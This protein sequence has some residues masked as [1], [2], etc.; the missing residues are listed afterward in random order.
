MRVKDS[1]YSNFQIQEWH[2]W[3][4]HCSIAVLMCW[5]FHTFPYLKNNMAVLRLGKV[6]KVHQL[7]GRGRAEIKQCAFVVVGNVS[8]IWKRRVCS[9]SVLS[10]PQTGI[11]PGLQHWTLG[12]LKCH[13]VETICSA[14]LKVK[15]LRVL[16]KGLAN[17][18]T[19]GQ[20]LKS[21]IWVSKI[22]D[23]GCQRKCESFIIF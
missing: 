20:E 14:K 6:E 3:H 15:L 1:L 23:T 9:I 18:G 22:L 17:K 5:N 19:C 12:H 21:V 13:T 4:P 16:D 7:E 11:F 2:F 10:W 8:C